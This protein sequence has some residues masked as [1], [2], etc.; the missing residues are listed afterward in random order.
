M[1]SISLD[2]AL[3]G[4]ASLAI[5]I[6][7]LCGDDSFTNPKTFCPN[8]NASQEQMPRH[9]IAAFRLEL[10]YL[11]PSL[12]V[13][14]LPVSYALPHGRATACV[15]R[16]PSRSGYCLCVTPFLTVGLLPGWV[17]LSLTSGR[18]NVPK[19]LHGRPK[20]PPRMLPRP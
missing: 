7:P 20:M 9:D 2:A 6:S 19:L 15:L 12:T 1:L 17:D 3:D 4:A 10:N 8:T 16:P 11:A 13:G 18:A 14:L 5:N